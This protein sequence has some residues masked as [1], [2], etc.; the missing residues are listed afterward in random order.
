MVDSVATKNDESVD[1]RN[2]AAMWILECLGKS[3]EE[4][5]YNVAK[6]RGLGNFKEMDEVE[7]AGNGL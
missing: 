7:T 2:E 6:K 4:E 1:R 5:F 3:F